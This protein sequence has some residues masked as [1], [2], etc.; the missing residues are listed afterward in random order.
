MKK[1]KNIFVHIIEEDYKRKRKEQSQCFDVSGKAILLTESQTKDTSVVDQ[2]KK[3]HEPFMGTIE[4]ECL[5]PSDELKQTN[6]QDSN[7]SRNL[8]Y[9]PEL[10]ILLQKV[11]TENKKKICYL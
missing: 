2:L 4:S 6:H 9:D 1:N 5:E 11:K 8:L 3:Q 7:D 10:D